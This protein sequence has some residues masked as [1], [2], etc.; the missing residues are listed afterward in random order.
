[1]RIRRPLNRTSMYG[2]TDESA[3]RHIV[4][5]TLDIIFKKHYAANIR[6][7]LVANIRTNNGISVI[8]SLSDAYELIAEGLDYEDS[9]Y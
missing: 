8:E 1:M 7:A 5:S 6:A 9:D 2:Y 3:H 4:Y